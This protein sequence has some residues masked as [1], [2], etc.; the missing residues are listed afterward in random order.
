MKTET[1]RGR[2]YEA[3]ERG[4]NTEQKG[5]KEIRVRKKKR[6]WIIASLKMDIKQ[7][8][9]ERDYAIQEK[10]GVTIDVLEVCWNKQLNLTLSRKN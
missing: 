7:E 1:E 8:M 2:E 5:Q 10:M 6:D 9:Q 3:K 4:G